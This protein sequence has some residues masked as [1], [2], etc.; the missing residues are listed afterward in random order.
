MGL[1]SA[2]ALAATT[3]LTVTGT[4][5]PAACVPAFAN[6]GIIDYGTLAV[7]ELEDLNQ[8]QYRL[9]QKT[10]NFAIDCSA[11]T[12]FALITTDNRRDSDLGL[13]LFSLG[14][15]QDQLIGTYRVRWSSENVLLDGVQGTT[16]ESLNSGSSWSI[17]SNSFFE[18]TGSWPQFRLGFSTGA[19]PRPTAASSLRVEMDIHG[20]IQKDLP[21][22]DLIRLDGNATVELLYL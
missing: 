3:D 21:F 17:V 18:D 16:V 9:P 12:T 4:I 13:S 2:N 8:N 22:S 19:V 20:S 1:A 15:H 7:T 11:P 5:T 10:L 6:G 14:R